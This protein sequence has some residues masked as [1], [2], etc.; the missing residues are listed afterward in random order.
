VSETETSRFVTFDCNRSTCVAVLSATAETK[1]PP[2]GVVVIV[3][4]P[5]YRVGSHRQFALLARALALAGIPTLRF[6]CRGMGDSDGEPRTFESIDDDIR[7]AID[8][9]SREAGVARVVLWG[10]CDGATAALLYGASDPRVAGIIALNPWARTT[11]GEAAARLKH[12]YLRRLGSLD[13]WRK[14]VSGR[15]QV[16]A[17]A[18]GLA[19]NV[20]NAVKRNA[21]TSAGSFLDRMEAGWRRFRRPMLVILSGNDLTAREFEA[22]VATESRRRSLLDDPLTEVAALTSAD[23]TFSDRASRDAVAAKS[24]EWILRLRDR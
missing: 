2:V 5:Q 17:S 7:A 9:L 18:G 21:A 20:R 10:L 19:A 4:G 12:Y 11:P 14:V 8:A 23:H 24:V 13:F 1:S 3:G 16:R 22:W 6:D 15:F